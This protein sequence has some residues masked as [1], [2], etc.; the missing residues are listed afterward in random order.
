MSPASDIIDQLC[1]IL[2]ILHSSFCIL[3]KIFPSSVYA[4]LY[5]LPSQPSVFKVLFKSCFTFEYCSTFLSSFFCSHIGMK[6][7]NISYRKNPSH[8]L[9]PFPLFPTVLNPSF[10]SPDPIF[11]IPCSPK[12]MLLS[13]AL[14]QCLYILSFN[15]IFG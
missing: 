12:L 13:I 8:M 10:Q 1:A 7:F 11:G 4:L 2:S 3:P 5:H 15:S 14:I 9:S 6:R